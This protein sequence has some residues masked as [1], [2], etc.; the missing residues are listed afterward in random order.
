MSSIKQ[1]ILQS[2]QKPNAKT[3]NDGMWQ[4]L[5]LKLPYHW[6]A[7]RLKIV[8]HKK[9]NAERQ[10]TRA[11]TPFE[12]LHRLSRISVNTN[13]I[14]VLHLIVLLSWNLRSFNKNVNNHE[15]LMLHK[16][17][18]YLTLSGPGGGPQRPGWPN[19]QLTIRNLLLYDAETWWLLI[20][21]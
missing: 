21:P 2:L 5:S 10:L 14:D 17:R 4:F 11:Q 20:C 6:T 19:S 18:T 7:I 16:L 15:H 8:N 12:S 3:T 13:W 9:F 1:C